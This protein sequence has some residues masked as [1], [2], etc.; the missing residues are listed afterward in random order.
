M[1]YDK[2]YGMSDL[3]QRAE[4][5]RA[6]Y[7]V[8]RQQ[9]VRHNRINQIELRIILVCHKQKDLYHIVGL[10]EGHFSIIWSKSNLIR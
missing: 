1:V 2:E 6:I 5:A 8:C 9:G 7:Y 3:C 10:H 4:N